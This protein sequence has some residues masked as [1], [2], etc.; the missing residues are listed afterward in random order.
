[1]WGT[2]RVVSFLLDEGA[3]MHGELIMLSEETPENPF[4]PAP[5]PEEE[6]EVES[7]SSGE[8]DSEK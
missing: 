2:I 7:N 6:E 8:D 4:E 5:E 3:F 1:M